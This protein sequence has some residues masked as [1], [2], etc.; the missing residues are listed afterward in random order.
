MSRDIVAALTAIVGEARVLTGDA[1]AAVEFPWDTHSGCTARAIVEPETT[2]EV[3]AILRCCNA[4]GQTVV[5]FGGL[6]NQTLIVCEGYDRWGCA[7]ALCVLNNARL[8]AVHDGDTRV[9]CTKV[10]TDN[11]SHDLG[12]FVEAMLRRAG[13]I[14]LLRSDPKIEPGA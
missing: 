9:C 7:C 14:W 11:F 3:A 10:D 5:P 4:A 6:T 1:V 12:P 13:P 2:D 8:R